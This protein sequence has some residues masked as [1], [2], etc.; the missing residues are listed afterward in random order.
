MSLAI[1]AYRR[2]LNNADQWQI[3]IYS[4]SFFF[5]FSQLNYV[6]AYRLHNIQTGVKKN[7]ENR[8]CL[9]TIFVCVFFSFKIVFLI[10]TC[11]SNNMEKNN[12]YLVVSWL[13]WFVENCLHSFV[14]FYSLCDMTS[15]LIKW[16]DW[17]VNIHYVV[18]FSIIWQYI[19]DKIMQ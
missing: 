18:F 7:Y 15:R 3:L 17:S 9:R 6:H 11:A 12:R 19:H 13:N 2:I 14:C 10:I 4:F 1:D 16:F 5:C 8:F